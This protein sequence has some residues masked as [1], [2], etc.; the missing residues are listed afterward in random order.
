MGLIKTSDFQ[1]APKRGR[2]FEYAAFG[3]VQSIKALWLSFGRGS[4]DDR[5]TPANFFASEC[6]ASA[7]LLDGRRFIGRRSA[8]R[9]GL[10]V[11]AVSRILMEKLA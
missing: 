9:V 2:L 8:C 6:P 4:G 5:S 7:L 11:Y 3:Q 1:S 10:C